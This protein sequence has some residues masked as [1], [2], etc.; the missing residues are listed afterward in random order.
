M[1]PEV[2]ILGVCALGTYAWMCAVVSPL[3]RSVKAVVMRPT[4]KAWSAALLAVGGGLLW[5]MVGCAALFLWTTIEP[6]AG[7][8]M[9]GTPF[10]VFGMAG[11]VATWLIHALVKRGVPRIGQAFET[12]TALSIVA[13]VREDPGM[14]DRVEQLYRAHAAPGPIDPRA[15]QLATGR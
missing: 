13:L 6:N 1:H 10:G 5:T 7:L 12:A 11:G 8:E 3:L 15:A 9:L 2:M 14:L 4:D